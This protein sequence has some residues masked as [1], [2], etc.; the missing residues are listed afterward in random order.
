MIHR[1]QDKRN[2][3]IELV[4]SKKPVRDI[5]GGFLC[6]EDVEPFLDESVETPFPV[7]REDGNLAGGEAAEASHLEEVD[8]GDRGVAGGQGP[9]EVNEDALRRDAV[10]GVGHLLLRQV[11]DNQVRPLSLRLHHQRQ[12]EVPVRVIRDPGGWNLKEEDTE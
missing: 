12:D 11:A 8:H 6:S 5:D 4:R 2:Q 10:P 3:P 9:I 7:R 1:A